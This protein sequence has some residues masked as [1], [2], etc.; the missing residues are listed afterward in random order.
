MRNE[1]EEELLALAF[2]QKLSPQEKGVLLKKYIGS[3][4]VPFLEWTDNVRVSKRKEE[5]FNT[6]RKAFDSKREKERMRQVGIGWISIFDPEY[7]HLLRNM[8]AAPILLFYKGKRGLLQYS[9]IG[10]VGARDCTEY[11]RQAVQSLLP[12]LVDKRYSIVSGLA[13][14]VDTLAHQLAI[15][16]NGSTI[17]VIGTG[18]DSYYPFENRALQGRIEKEHLLLSEYPLGV[19]P[20][21]HHF[22]YRN[23]I[24]AGLA[25]GL[26]V[27][28]AK[29]R[30]GS[31]ITAH[32]A[33]DNG[34]EVFA[35]PGSIF[36]PHSKGCNKLIQVGAKAVL[37]SSDVLEEFMY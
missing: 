11:G 8:Y 22:P 1:M 24:I 36:Q 2:Y 21:R 27:I 12:A 4:S 15:R 14:G 13:R 26:I 19:G 18:L 10:V 34:K 28:E 3:L 16:Q 5:N 6:F 9:S 20:K 32:Q 17:A 33:L 30:S 7:P 31:L 25:K 37:Q 23:R 35:V 29:E